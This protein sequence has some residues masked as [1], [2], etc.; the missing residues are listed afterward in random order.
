MFALADEVG[1]AASRE[2]LAGSVDAVANVQATFRSV[3]FFAYDVWRLTPLV[4]S[5]LAW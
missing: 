1:N 2:N 5:K 4:R 3:P